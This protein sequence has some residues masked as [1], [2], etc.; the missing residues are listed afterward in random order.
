MPVRDLV[1]RT[2]GA[3]AVLRRH[4]EQVHGVESAVIFGSYADGRLKSDS[5]VDV[6]VVGEVDR[7][8]LTEAL[9][10]AAT[11]LGREVNEVVLTRNELVRRRA[12]GNGLV[13]S[14]DSGHVARVIV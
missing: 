6:L 12:A 4:L 9:E 3:P 11:E 14:I 7:D 1:R 5:D 13:K 8:Q 2:I 10:A